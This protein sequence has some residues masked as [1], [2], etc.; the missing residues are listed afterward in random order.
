MDNRGRSVYGVGEEPDPRFSMANERTT[1]A[2]LRTAM[3]PRRRRDRPALGHRRLARAAPLGA[4]HRRRL[5]LGGAAL[6]VRAVRRWAQVERAMRQRQPLPAPRALVWLASGIRA[7]AILVLALV[8]VE[9]A[10][11]GPRRPQPSARRSPAARTHRPGLVADRPRRQRPVAPLLALQVQRRL[12]VLAAASALAAGAVAWRSTTATRHAELRAEWAGRPTR[13]S[14]AGDRR[15][16]GRTR[17]YGDRGRRPHR[18]T[19][20]DPPTQGRT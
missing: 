19:E 10:D 20:G 11:D 15:G 6:A 1:L 17:R 5:C 4:R 14:S 12:W 18:L 2:W 8:V 13:C 16:C 3:A 9:L 7:L